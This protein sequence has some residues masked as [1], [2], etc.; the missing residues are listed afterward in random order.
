MSTPSSGDGSARRGVGFAV[1]WVLAAIVAVSVGLVAVNGLGASIR[2]RGPTVNDAIHEAQLNEER[3][4]IASADPDDERHSKEIREEF[5]VFEVEC[6]G[7]IATGSRPE[8][9]PGWRIVGYETGPD[10]DVDAVFAKAAESIEIEVFCNRGIPTVAD[11][12]RKT[13]PEGDD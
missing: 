7:P 6:Q 12:E 2:D 8:P 13:L 4:G 11:L 9:A 3:E 5:G 10:D 1:A